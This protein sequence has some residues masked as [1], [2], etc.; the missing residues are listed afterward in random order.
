VDGA[1]NGVATVTYWQAGVSN[2]F[3]KYVVD[4]MVNLTAYVV[5]FFGILFRKVQTGRIQT[6][7]AYAVLGVVVIFLVYYL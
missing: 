4:G 1:V 6:Y 3:D 2:L 7:I 5:G